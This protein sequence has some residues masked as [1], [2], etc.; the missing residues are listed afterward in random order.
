MAMGASTSLGRYP[1]GS[2]TYFL[3]D[4]LGSSSVLIDKS[5]HVV[6]SVSYYPFGEVRSSG[7]YSKY[8]YNSKE[9]DETGLL[10]YGARYY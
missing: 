3:D 9:L 2:R 4:H 1:N 10:Y 6:D 5:G 8:V 7:N